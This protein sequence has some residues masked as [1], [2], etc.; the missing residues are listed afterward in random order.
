MAPPPEHDSHRRGR[1]SHAE[2]GRSSAGRTTTVR[3]LFGATGWPCGVLEIASWAKREGLAEPVVVPVLPGY[4]FRLAADDRTYLGEGPLD[5]E[6]IGSFAGHQRPLSRDAVVRRTGPDAWEIADRARG[7]TYR[8]VDGPEGLDVYVLES[9][10]PAESIALL[11]RFARARSRVNELFDRD[12]SPSAAT[13]GA[14]AAVGG[15]FLARLIEFAPHVVGFRLEGGGF[16]Q[17]KRFIQAVRLVSNAEVVLGGP[18]PTSH[19]AEVLAESGADYVFAGEAEEPF[20]QFL[21]L[22]WERNSK[23]RQPEIPGLAYRY[24]GRVYVNRGRRKRGGSSFSAKKSCVPFFPSAP[25]EVITANRLDWSLLDGFDRVE[26]DSL[27]FTGGR[28]CPGECTFCAKL[29][30]QEV[31]VKGARQLLDE[32][33]AADAKVAAGEIRVTRWPLFEHCDDPKLRAKEVAWAAVYDEDFFLHRRRAIEFLRLWAQSA[34]RQRYRLS[35]QTNPCSMLGADGRV[36]P[37]LLQW[38]DSVKP[39]VQLGAE[40]FNRELLARWRK[41]HNVDQL[42]TVLDAL[43]ATR[44]DYTVFQILTDFDTTPEELV[45]TLRLLILN[46][47]RHRRM[48]IASSPFTIPL[49]DSQ[50]RK[51][52]EYQGLLTPDRVRHFTD[53]ERPQPG[54]MDP[55]AAELADLADAELRWTLQPP[56]RD[57]ALLSAFRVVLDRIGQERKRL[58]RAGDV[59]DRQRLRIRD[60]HDQAERAMRHI[61]DARFQGIEPLGR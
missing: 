28:G 19:P 26:L 40:S 7:W 60:L 46:A 32:I 12:G 11:R 4:A 24:G 31:R 8:V 33:E 61:M 25:R 42:N 59:A 22:A 16:E 49:Y 29:H 35:V 37:E 14:L 10:E 34:L 23:D 15:R 17:V 38:I 1:L 45:D 18:T 51:R 20:N 21:R 41:R 6:V 55:L 48:R 57:A 3:L 5:P 39:M 52:L 50:T 27:F 9:Y 53:Y 36:D 2:R 44:Q 13:R 56:R 54:W 47:Y 30:G 58:E 43:D